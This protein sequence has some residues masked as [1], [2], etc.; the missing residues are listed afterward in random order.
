MIDRQEIEKKVMEFVRE[1][2]KVAD[3]ITEDMS[4]RDDLELD[5]VDLTE[6]IF[7]LEDML[8]EPIHD[9]EL[10]HLTT[11]KSAVDFLEKRKGVAP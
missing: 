10:V 8:G 2:S 6:M 11:I 4:F 5:S 3:P 7:L 9:S 1:K